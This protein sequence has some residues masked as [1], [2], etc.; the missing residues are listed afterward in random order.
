MTVK[1]VDKGWKKILKNLKTE[2]GSYAK[3]GIQ[4][5]AGKNEE[6]ED[7]TAYIYEYAAANEFGTKKIPSRPFIRKTFD[8]NKNKIDV[9]V[10]SLQSDIY[11]GKVDFKKGLG[12]LGQWYEGVIKESIKNTNWEPNAP[13]TIE[14]KGSSKP[15]ID[16][17]TMRN[18]IRSVEV[19]K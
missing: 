18:S 15:L 6:D 1:D 3:V 19:F 2:N 17:G 12:Q 7:S 10:L 11:K 8:E 9:K 5:D 13:S 14:K 4:S 16:T